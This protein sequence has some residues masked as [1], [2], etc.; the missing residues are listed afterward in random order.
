MRTDV[1]AAGDAR[2]V[3]AEACGVAGDLDVLVNNAGVI[4]TADF[5]DVAEADFDR[6]LRVNLKGMF[7]VG[8]ILMACICIFIA[9]LLH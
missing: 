2:N 7:L 9:F 8:L 6:V 3:V 5:L 4:H 1:G